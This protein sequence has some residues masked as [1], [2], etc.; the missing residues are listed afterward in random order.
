MTNVASAVKDASLNV[1]TVA[2]A[3]EELRSSIAEIARQV[4]QSSTIAGKAVDDARHTDTIVQNLA[5]GAQR[6][7]DVVGLINSMAGQTNLLALNAT[8]EAARA[9]DAGKGFA[10][11]ASEVKSLANQTA[12][13]TEDI[14]K[15]IQ[16][17]QT[18]TGE[19][20]QA[21]ELIARTIE[22]L[23]EIAS[24]IALAV[25][26]Q[27]SATQEIARNVQ[28]AASGT[29]NVSANIAGVGDGAKE[30]GTAADRVLSAASDLSGQAEQLRSDIRRF[31][32][33]VKAA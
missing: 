10:V 24:S 13:A 3:A 20:V 33:G 29:Q 9:G 4:A 12:K 32:S 18:A 28:E 2:S 16:E 1:Q 22:E 5:S 27:G 8:I 6:I 30:T 26:E 17:I 15:Q 14:S 19:A 11:V 23:S 7:G 31:I 21:I 25:E